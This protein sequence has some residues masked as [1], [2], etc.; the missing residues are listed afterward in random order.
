MDTGLLALI[1]KPGLVNELPGKWVAYSVSSDNCWESFPREGLLA[2]F[3]AIPGE[4][5]VCWE[6]DVGLGSASCSSWLGIAAQLQWAFLEGL[7]HAA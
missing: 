7:A 3:A 1:P 4:T 5:W 6:A 2:I